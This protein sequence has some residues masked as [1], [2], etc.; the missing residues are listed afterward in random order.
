MQ[1]NFIRGKIPLN[2]IPPMTAIVCPTDSH[3]SGT[4]SLEK[5]IREAAGPELA[6]HLAGKHLAPHTCLV[7]DG[8]Q[9]HHKFLIHVPV[10]QA[11]QLSQDPKCLQD[12]YSAMLRTPNS[13]QHGNVTA[14]ITHIATP[15]LG[16][17]SAGWDYAASMSALWRAVL[18]LQSSFDYKLQVL[19]IYYPEEAQEAVASYLYRTSQ[20]FFSNNRAWSA[21]GESRLWLDLMRHFDNPNFNRINP[22]EFVE[23]IQRFFHNKT[24]KW[25]CGDLSVTL[26]E[27]RLG[28]AHG[29]V[30]Q[31]FAHLTV[32]V[33][34]SNLVS[35]GYFTKKSGTFLIPVTMGDYA[36]TL[37]Y[38]LLPLLTHLR[39]DGFRMNDTIRYSL[40]FQNLYFV[41]I[42]HHKYFPDLIDH[43]SLDVEDVHDRHYNFS[44]AAAQALVRHFHEHPKAL[45]RG[46]KDYLKCCG[47]PALEKLVISVSSGTF[48]Y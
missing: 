7:T 11:S 9:L 27:Y 44:E 33:L 37:P 10:P 12:T 16:T 14:I 45:I 13:L 48:S 6:A 41:T 34:V 43:Y 29:T 20:A 36:L 2:R 31:G 22:K 19:D 5:A 25:L 30:G 26:P 1:V 21:W 46:M 32:P 8:Y 3:L 28:H 42:H 35:L 39:S 18:D 4:G 23:E 40:D 17:G 47:G 24:G 38:D 15:L